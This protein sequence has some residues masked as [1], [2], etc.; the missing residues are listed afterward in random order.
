[1]TRHRRCCWP[2]ISTPVHHGIVSKALPYRRH[3]VDALRRFGA[4]LIP[5]NCR[6]PCCRWRSG[7]TGASA[8][9]IRRCGGHRKSRSPWL[10]LLHVPST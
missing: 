7:L 1:V 4:P 10:P 3:S 9:F 8:R 6:C 5:R 2:R